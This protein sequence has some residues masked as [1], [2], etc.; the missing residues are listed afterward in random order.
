MR[1]KGIFLAI[2]Y[3]KANRQGKV[4]GIGQRVDHN[5]N[6]NNNKLQIIRNS[7]DTTEAESADGQLGRMISE[8]WGPYNSDTN[9]F[10]V[11]I[12]P[13]S[14]EHSS[15]KW[16]CDEPRLKPAELGMISLRGVIGQDQYLLKHASYSIFLVQRLSGM[17]IC[18]VIRARNLMRSRQINWRGVQ[19]EQV[20]RSN[21]V[22]RQSKHSRGFRWLSRNISLSFSVYLAASRARLES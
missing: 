8:I 2:K 10:V 9:M 17:Q 7:N 18:S 6:N 12:G 13:L 1:I 3:L 15:Q 22:E 11:V 21:S 19:L 5:N 20:C 16:Q 14:I 4:R